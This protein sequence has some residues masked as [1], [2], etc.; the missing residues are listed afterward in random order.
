MSRLRRPHP[1]AVLLVALG[2]LGVGGEKQPHPPRSL[3]APTQTYSL[4]AAVVF[5][6][7]QDIYYS[8]Y[9][10]TAVTPAAGQD[11]RIPRPAQQAASWHWWSIGADESSDTT[12]IVRPVAGGDNASTESR[13]VLPLSGHGGVLEEDM[14]RPPF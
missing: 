5:E 14:G 4:D 13:P 10:H 6:K 7:D 12:T 3:H 11:P 2:L 8:L 1:V 9:G